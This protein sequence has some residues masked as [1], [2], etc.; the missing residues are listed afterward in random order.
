MK[1]F[2]KYLTEQACPVATRDISVNIKNRQIAIDSYGYGPA[3]PNDKEADND[4]F[5]KTKAKMWKCS[6]DNVMTM[7]CGNC[8]AFDI[9]DTMRACIES[10]IEGKEEG[11]DAMATIE[12]SDIG[13]CNFLHFK[14]AGD[15]TC[16]AWITNGPIDNK[17]RTE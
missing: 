4:A 2:I 7:K 15:R 5:W 1:S 14:C 8:G 16:D 12:K 3:N 10:G 6:V 9:S 13:Y 11:V 17:D